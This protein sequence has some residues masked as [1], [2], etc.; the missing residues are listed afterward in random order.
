MSCYWN[1]RG[2]FYLD[3]F[4]I[5][6][7]LF[8]WKFVIIQIHLRFINNVRPVY[9]NGELARSLNQLI[10]LLYKSGESNGITAHPSTFF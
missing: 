9:K 1:K 2:R 7:L 4:Q 5:N 6:C 10:S 8:D 3:S